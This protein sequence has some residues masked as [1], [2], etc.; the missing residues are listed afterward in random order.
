MPCYQ[1][2]F[3]LVQDVHALPFGATSTGQ[4]QVGEN[5]RA[6]GFVVREGSWGRRDHHSYPV[7]PPRCRNCEIQR[8]R[9][10]IERT[11][12]QWSQ[13]PI[14]ILAAAGR[15]IKYS[16]ARRLYFQASQLWL[17]AWALDAGARLP[18]TAKTLAFD[19][20]TVFAFSRRSRQHDTCTS[21][22]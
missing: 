21:A 16:A 4:Q 9:R 3:V 14:N 22:M 11:V 1:I 6:S 15:Y 5:S 17:G 10:Q 2:N 19:A 18:I 7:F 20:T 13:E 12:A 8:R